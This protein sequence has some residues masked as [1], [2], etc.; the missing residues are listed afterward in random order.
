MTSRRFC[1]AL[2]LNAMALLIGAVT[3]GYAEG[4]IAGPP[5]A[6]L[7]SPGPDFTFS[8]FQNPL[9]Y[10]DS[11]VALNPAVAAGLRKN[12]ADAQVN[13][14][15]VRNATTLT[16]AD[17]S[18]GAKGGTSKT[19]KEK[20]QPSLSF[21]GLYPLKGGQRGALFGIRSSASMNLDS[22][23]T[24]KSNYDT[25][26]QSS[27]QQGLTWPLNASVGGL[28]AFG[29]LGKG[30]G[31]SLDLGYHMEPHSFLTTKNVVG[32]NVVTTYSDALNPYDVYGGSV[33]LRGGL[34]HQLSGSSAFSVAVGLTG[35]L[36]DQSR[37]YTAVDTNGDGTPDTLETYHEWYLSKG[38]GAPSTTAASFSARDRSWH[39]AASLSPELR[40]ALTNSLELF[41]DGTWNGFDLTYRTRYQHIGYTGSPPDKSL[42]DTYLNS[43]LGSGRVLVGL[44]F[45]KRAGSELRA[46]I[47]YARSDIRYSQDGTDAAGNSVYS[48]LNPNHYPEVKLGTSPAYDAVVQAVSQLGEPAWSNVSNQL[49]FAAG[50]QYRA[51]PKTRLF[52]DLNIGAGIQSQ[53]YWVFNLDTRTPWN[54][55]VTS[56]SIDWTLHGTAGIAMTLSKSAVLT[57]DG[58]SNGTTGTLSQS[59]ETLPFDASFGRVTTNG[60]SDQVTSTPFSF[61]IHAGLSWS[62]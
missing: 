58:T 15:Y 5:A 33:D 19:V 49:Q 7:G 57:I 46:G 38:P 10:P 32:S 43:S 12:F 54:E 52:A 35:G 44:A 11:T 45:H 8:Q 31:I 14:P 6:S 27:S 42:A 55:T 16:R 13:L 51:G 40:V 30:K 26:G 18:I 48:T 61:T 39:M 60:A 29:K 62:R 34:Q 47:G 9:L 41:T 22:S 2:V 4:Q 59:S 3:D 53:E 50:W 36:T 37:Q 17:N 23:A 20:L 25:N 21:L 1:A 28:Y 56:K 24:V